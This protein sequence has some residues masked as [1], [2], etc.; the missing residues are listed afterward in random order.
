METESLNEANKGNIAKKGNPN[1]KH[2]LVLLLYTLVFM[3]FVFYS[4]GAPVF[5]NLTDKA[6]LFSLKVGQLLSVALAFVL[7][8]VLYVKFFTDDKMQFLKLKKP[9]YPWVFLLIP[10]A[11]IT[12]LPLIN[13]LATINEMISL[14]E[15]LKGLEAWMKASEENA[16]LLTEAFLQMDGPLDFLI[17]I[18]VIA[19]AAAFSEELFFR[20]ALQS[21]LL[22]VTK[23]AHVSIW[24][25]ALLFSALHGQFYGF[26]PRAILGAALGYVFQWSGSLWVPIAAHFANNAFAVFLAFLI[27]KGIVSED[28]EQ[29]GT[30]GIGWIYVLISL[31]VSG[32]LLLLS[33]NKLK[34]GKPTTQPA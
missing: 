6:V 34:V 23:N 15:S 18:I 13:G 26:I 8:V 24:I 2:L 20:G 21:T 4:S 33:Y 17:N 3:G 5:Y 10:L 25:A 31:G 12:A 22:K 9:K 29:V 7:P 1:I 16:K 11:F 30:E 32:G 27:Q 28:V 19:F 14:P